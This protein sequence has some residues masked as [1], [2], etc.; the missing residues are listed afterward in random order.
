MVGGTKE[1]PLSLGDGYFVQEDNVMLE[2]NVPPAYTAR[3][4]SYNIMVGRVRAVHAA[5]MS[6]IK[7]K[8]NVSTM[9]YARSEA[10]FSDEDIAD[11]A[12]AHIFGC[13]PDFDAY[14]RG[15]PAP[16]IDKSSLYIQGE[17]VRMAGGHVHIGFNNPNNV[18]LWVVARLCDYFI[19]YRQLLALRVPEQGIRGRTYGSP[20]RFRPTPYGLEYRTPSNWWVIKTSTTLLPPAINVGDGAIQVGRLVEQHDPHVIKDFIDNMPWGV[21][22]NAIQGNGNAITDRMEL[23]A[24]AM[25]ALGVYSPT[26]GW[27]DA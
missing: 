19:Y 21:V 6:G 25:K 3:N 4:F 26:E 23:Q 1:A 22:C 11:M 7:K 10:R 5:L 16:P 8:L 15:E 14:N 2:Y 20:G 18:P 12:Q 9:P 17:H 27:R 13:S 24:I